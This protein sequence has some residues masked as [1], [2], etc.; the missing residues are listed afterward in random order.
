MTAQIKQI[1]EYLF[2]LS[3]KSKHTYRSYDYAIKLF[4]E[5]MSIQSWEDIENIT[6]ANIEN[7]KNIIKNIKP[8]N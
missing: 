7:Y 4:C 1:D 8:K 2:S 3:D 5:K 6:S